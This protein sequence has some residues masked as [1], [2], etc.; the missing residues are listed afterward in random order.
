M[1]AALRAVLWLLAV[2]AAGCAAPPVEAIRTQ[3]R[4]ERAIAASDACL[5]GVAEKR[6]RRPLYRR[7]AV[8]PV[9]P[10]PEPSA[11]QLA[12]PD[13]LDPALMA[14]A[15][16]M[17]ADLIPCREAL[18]RDIA[19]AAPEIASLAGD[20]L[21]RGDAAVLALL[22]GEIAVGETNRR[23]AAVQAEFRARLPEAVA[24]VRVRIGLTEA[25]TAAPEAQPDAVAPDRFPAELQAMHGAM[26]LAALQ[27]VR[28][29]ALAAEPP[30][31]GEARR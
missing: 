5:E 8:A 21:L 4:I 2:A 30:R 3:R 1:E 28:T 11:A 15:V 19:E 10:Q 7:L 20:L 31:S 17:H 13:P 6:E 26:A 9:V 23:I 12:D 16:A 24:R 25:D 18:V 14:M 27:A 29:A 22:R